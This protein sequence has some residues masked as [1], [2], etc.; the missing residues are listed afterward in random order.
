MSH[1]T[2]PHVKELQMTSEQVRE[3]VELRETILGHDMQPETDQ[4]DV[5]IETEQ[6]PS[7]RHLSRPASEPETSCHALLKLLTPEKAINELDRIQRH[8]NVHGMQ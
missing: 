8:F 6:G 1:P 5:A 3:L 7:N 2:A 4:N